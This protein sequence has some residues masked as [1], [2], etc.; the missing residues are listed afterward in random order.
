VSGELLLNDVNK[1]GLLDLLVRDA[2]GAVHVFVQQPGKG[3]NASPDQTL[4]A[5][6]ACFAMGNLAPGGGPALIVGQQ[7][8]GRILL[9]AGVKTIP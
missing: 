1:D 5:D 7:K 2:S 4:K 9:F 3:L 6:A 8:T